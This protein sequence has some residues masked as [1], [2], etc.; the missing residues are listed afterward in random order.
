MPGDEG[1]GCG[2]SIGVTRVKM[3]VL[4]FGFSDFALDFFD[5]FTVSSSDTVLCAL[6]L[7]SS[8]SSLG[9]R[10][11]GIST[12]TGGAVDRSVGILRVDNKTPRSRRH[13]S[14]HTATTNRYS[15]RQSL[16]A[17]TSLQRLG[18]SFS[19]R[20]WKNED[21]TQIKEGSTTGKM[22]DFSVQARGLTRNTAATGRG[23][24]RKASG[25]SQ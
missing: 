2:W 13:L 20:Q 15:S 23:T 21:P 18:P 7:T 17:S 5:F 11:F 22:L 6:S 4:A 9:S 25:N 16:V 24:N 14:P 19:T 10:R 8:S 1:Q 3:A 12:E